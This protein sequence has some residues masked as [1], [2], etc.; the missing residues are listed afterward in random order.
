MTNLFLYD[1]TRKYLSRDFAENT[2]ISRFLI[3]ADRLFAPSLH[4]CCW[5]S[6]S[7]PK[8]QTQKKA[9]TSDSLFFTSDIIVYFGELHL[10]NAQSSIILPA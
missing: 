8:A 4:P 10:I 2:I 5:D 9:T 1:Y 7:A 6:Q 3:K